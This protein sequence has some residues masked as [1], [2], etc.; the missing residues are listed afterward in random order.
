MKKIL[1]ILI[2]LFLSFEV[3]PRGLSFGSGLSNGYRDAGERLRNERTKVRGDFFAALNQNMNYCVDM[4]K[5]DIR[6]LKILIASSDYLLMNSI[7]DINKI[8]TGY[9]KKYSEVCK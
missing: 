1:L 7:G 6:R 5:E 2:C 3:N 8:Y 9:K 4:S